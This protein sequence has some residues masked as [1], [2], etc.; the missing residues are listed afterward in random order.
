MGGVEVARGRAPLGATNLVGKP[1]TVAELTGETTQE[2]TI[3]VGTTG[4]TGEG[5]LHLLTT[6][7]GEGTLQQTT[8]TEKTNG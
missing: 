5:A 2:M 8:V 1:E 3:G 6:N 4:V 7:A